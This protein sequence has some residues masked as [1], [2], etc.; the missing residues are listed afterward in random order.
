MVNSVRN[1]FNHN[2]SGELYTQFLS[3]INAHFPGAL[4]FRI[5]ETPV[6]INRELREKMI[7]TCEYIISKIQS[8]DFISQT[9]RSILPFKKGKSPEN[10][11]QFIAFDFGICINEDGNTEP[12]LIELQ[13][14]PTLFGFQAFFPSILEKYFSIPEGYSQF[15]GDY[16]RASY[17]ALLKKTI[18]GNCDPESVILLE[19]NPHEQKTRIDF[20]CT[21]HYLGINIVCISEIITEGKKIF[22][23]KDSQKIEVR[24]IYNRVIGDELLQVKQQ[25]DITFDMTD[26]WEVEWIPHPSWFYR[27]SKFALPL[28]K[29]A[30]I[31][32]TKLL[33]SFSSIPSNLKD[34]VLKP[35]FSFAGQGVIID[36]KQEDIEAVTDP[37]NWILQRKMNYADCIHTPDGNAKAEIRIMYIWDEEQKKQVPVTNLARLSKGKMIGTRYNKNKTWVGGTVAYFEQ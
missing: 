7:E 4:D 27:I 23:Y 12:A 32:E 9:D 24:R 22:Y 10:P 3:E 15:L 29:H 2:F 33:S 30:Y 25:M 28:L 31:P 35:L 14:F 21:A 19:I 6:F 26:E 5:A 11:C 37:E 36:V 20:Y 17:I 1:Q 18:I 16:N 34:F 8:H 13:G